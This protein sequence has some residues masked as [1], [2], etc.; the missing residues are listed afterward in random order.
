MITNKN[1]PTLTEKCTLIAEMPLFDEFGDYGTEEEE[2]EFYC[3]EFAVPSKEVNNAVQN[4][5]KPQKGLIMHDMEYACE[6]KVIFNGEK[7]HIYRYYQRSDGF[8]ELYLT[9]RLCDE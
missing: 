9:K 3:A 1:N 2:F 8:V 6:K 4:G 7:Y 5:I